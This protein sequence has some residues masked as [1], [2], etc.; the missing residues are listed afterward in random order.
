MND[1]ASVMQ[2]DDPHEQN[3]EV[4]CGD[5]KEVDRYEIGDVVFQERPPRWGRRSARTD[6]IFLYRRFRDFDANLVQLPDD[7]W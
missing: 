1:L 4:D 5:C 2:E 7:T 3:F 6:S